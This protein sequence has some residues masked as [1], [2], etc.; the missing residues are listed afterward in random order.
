MLSLPVQTVF[1]LAAPAAVNDMTSC[2][3]L[4]QVKA[5]RNPRTAN[6]TRPETPP[7]SSHNGNGLTDSCRIWWEGARLALPRCLRELLF[8]QGHQLQRCR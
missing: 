1:D 5:P 4:E 8:L 7:A 2:D 3:F 6:W